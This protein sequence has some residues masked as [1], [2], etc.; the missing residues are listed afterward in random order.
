[1][2]ILHTSDWHLTRYLYR[3]KRDEEFKRFLDWLADTIEKEDVAAL[4]VSGDVFDTTTPGNYA[5]TLYYRF[6]A[7]VATNSCCRNIV[8]VA[9]NHDSPSFLNAPSHI[10]E[11]L[12][13]FVVAASDQDNPEKEV[14]PLKDEN[15]K[16]E[17]IVC[18]VPY[19]R[20]RDI[21]A[22]EPGETITDKERALV[23]GIQAHYKSVYE[24]ADR[25]R[26]ELEKE[27]GGRIPVIATGHLFAAG[28]KTS[29]GDG[30]RELY[31]G[32]LG[33]VSSSIFPSGIDYAA[34]GHLHIPQSVGGNELIRYSGSPIPMSFGEGKR[35]KSVVIVDFDAEK[36]PDVKLVSVPLF[37]RLETIKGGRDDIRAA[38]GEL[39]AE[40]CSI[41]LEIEYTGKE[42]VHD[43][44]EE[45][46]ELVEGS[47]LRIL[48]IINRQLID[49]VMSPEHENETLDD[50]DEKDVFQRCM[51]VHEVPAEQQKTLMG[52]YEE[53][54]YKMENPE[55]SI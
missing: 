48:R 21:R 37:Q 41:W 43:L 6:L 31:I 25:R 4:V 24:I 2:K 44:K 19:L 53:I 17:A 36:S 29:D 12:N 40:K 51:D 49:R 15:G 9:G 52:L 32:S 35:E 42:I 28:G 20:E 39:K 55:D 22:S 30:V 34:L 26:K 27:S 18:A 8:I 3:Q 1:M 46:E 54:L 14:L 11:A 33:H 45:L 47:D 10:L 13:V 23:Q 5:R 7:K 50:L 16:V 38:I